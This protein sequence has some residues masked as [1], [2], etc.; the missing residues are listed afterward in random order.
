MN[1]VHVNATQQQTPSGHRKYF[2]AALHWFMNCFCFVLFSTRLL[3]HVFEYILISRKCYY[4]QINY[5]YSLTIISFIF[6]FNFAVRP[7]Q[8]QFYF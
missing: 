1:S 7:Q 6:F 5:I 2:Y 3:P 4:S 8:T